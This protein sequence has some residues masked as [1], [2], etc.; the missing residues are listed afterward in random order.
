MESIKKISH[1]DGLDLNYRL[2]NKDNNE[3]N[4]KNKN[5]KNRSRE[6]R[7]GYKE[8]Q[9]E[10]STTSNDSLSNYKRT[11]FSPELNR[12]MQIKRLGLDNNIERE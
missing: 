7:D 3:S 8:K 4:G 9:E 1:I 5:S 10:K 6:F 11:Q 2:K 12:D